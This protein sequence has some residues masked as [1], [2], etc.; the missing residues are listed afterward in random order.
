MKILLIEDN[1]RLAERII[2]KLKGEL[3]LDHYTHGEEALSAL[4]RITYDVVLLDLSLPDL[5]GLEICKK[6]RKDKIDTPILVLTGSS[7]VK[8]RVELLNNGADD[9]MSKPF[10]AQELIAR[11]KALRR[12]GKMPLSSP[13]ITYKDLTIDQDQHRVHREGVEIILRRK[14]FQILTYL[15][16]NSGRILTRRMIIDHV[17]E[18]GSNS[19]LNTVDVHIKHLRDK[20]DAPFQEK[21]IKTAYGLGYKVA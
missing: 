11:I 8:R 12:R 16:K 7:A 20:V 3:V 14:E 15:T 19:W 17:W 9:F 1:E 5:S 10:D 13:K 18:V 6:I 2:H 4:D 21:Y